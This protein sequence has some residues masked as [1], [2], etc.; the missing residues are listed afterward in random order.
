MPELFIEWD[1][2]PPVQEVGSRFVLIVPLSD[3]PG[4]EWATQLQNYLLDSKEEPAG[5]TWLHNPRLI[6]DKIEVNLP[7]KDIPPSL[8]TYLDKIVM[9]TN[10]AMRAGH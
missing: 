7:N 5:R 4:D 2:L 3:L 10:D 8:R 9:L 6:G 1:Q